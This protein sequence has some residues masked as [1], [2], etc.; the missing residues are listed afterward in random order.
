MLALGGEELRPGLN[1]GV[2]LEQGATLTL[3]HTAPDAELDPV[4]QGVGTA[5]SDHRT[6]TA[7]DG[8]LAL[9]CPA[10]EELVG[11]SRPA[12]GLGYPG[13]PG[14]LRSADCY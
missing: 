5:F 3:G 10:H 12:Q 7:D 9:G 14:L 13:D 4:I 11:I 2:L 1:L 6:V 8:R